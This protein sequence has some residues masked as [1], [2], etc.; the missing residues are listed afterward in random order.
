MRY[1]QYLRLAGA[2]AILLGFALTLL[3]L[4]GVF[5]HYAAWWAGLLFVPGTLLLIGGKAARRGTPLGAPGRWLTDRPLRAAREGRDVLPAALLRRQILG[6]TSAFIVGAGAWIVLVGGI[7]LVFFGGGLALVAYGAL[8]LF[9]AAPR[10]VDVETRR[11]VRF[12]IHRRSLL[13]V[14]ELTS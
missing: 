7:G 14:P 4:P 11:R 10:I 5:L 2:C 9:W 3:A 6:E 12:R 8:Q 13:G 1:V